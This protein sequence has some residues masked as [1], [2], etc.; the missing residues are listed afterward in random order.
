VAAPVAAGLTVPGPLDRPE[1]LQWSYLPPP[2]SCAATTGSIR[3]DQTCSPVSRGRVRHGELREP[4]IAIAA[5]HQVEDHDEQIL[6]HGAKDPQGDVG[7]VTGIRPH[8][9]AE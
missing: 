6:G 3:F 7:L 9:D 2:M 8:E 5:G 4:G 1:L